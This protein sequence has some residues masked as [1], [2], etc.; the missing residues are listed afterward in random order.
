MSGMKKALY[1]LPFIISSA[2]V[3]STTVPRASFISPRVTD[4]VQQQARWQDATRAR[5]GEFVQDTK[6]LHLH[7]YENVRSNVWDYWSMG[8]GLGGGMLYASFPDGEAYRLPWPDMR[9]GF[10]R[11]WYLTNQF[12]AQF[13]LALLTPTF[14]LGYVVNERTR[15][16]AGMGVWLLGLHG[17]WVSMPSLED[18]LRGSSGSAAT[19]DMRH[20]SLKNRLVISPSISLDH[21]ISTN[22]FL[23]MTASY[24]QA[25]ISLNSPD[26]P[27][28]V[29]WPQLL[30]SLNFRF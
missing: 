4:Q 12:T 21:F 1:L 25:R 16:S 23:R 7:G 5:Q 18:R 26:R 20:Y 15:V 30:V 14:R 22:C 27:V 6:G 13:D 17:F 2:L 3:S 9:L 10:E 11:S 19:Q 8:F 29:H 28:M 24:D